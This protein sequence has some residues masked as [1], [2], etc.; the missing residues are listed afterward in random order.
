T[1]SMTQPC[2]E[3]DLRLVVDPASA[4]STATIR[5][6]QQ[7]TSIR[8]CRSGAR[9]DLYLGQARWGSAV[10]RRSSRSDRSVTSSRARRPSIRLSMAREFD[11]LTHY[12]FRYPAKFHPP[13]ARALL[14]RYSEP[15]DTVL[16]PF[17]GSG[18]LLV[19]AL[20]SDRSSVGIDVDP[21]ATLVSRAK[22]H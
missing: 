19:E 22:V 15:G 8:R 4:T 5:P 3:V 17:C 6:P 11:Q 2:S 14:E 10:S 20:V 12:L 7:L 16:D 9:E 1:S 18:T 21:V 13:V